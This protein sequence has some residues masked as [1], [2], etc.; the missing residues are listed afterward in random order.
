MKLKTLL[1]IA[2]IACVAMTLA[3]CANKSSKSA[4]PEA[5][6]QEQDTAR[7]INDKDEVTFLRTFLDNYL[8]LGRKEAQGLAREHLTQDFYS[9]YIEKS[10]NQDNAIDAIFETAPGDK[11]AKIDSMGKGIEEPSSFIVYV[12]V[13]GADKKAYPMQYDMDV[14]KVEGKFK[15]NDSE[16]ND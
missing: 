5:A 8:K 13:I 4:E 7:V 15:L 11:V 12:Q 16:M 9:V 3:A 1:N 14:I 10:N 2:V 6:S